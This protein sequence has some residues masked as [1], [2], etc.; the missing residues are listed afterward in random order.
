MAERIFDE[1]TL[2]KLDRLTLIANYK[3]SERTQ[4]GLKWKL[5]SGQPYTPIVG[6]AFI[7]YAPGDTAGY[8][9][10]VPGAKVF[11]DAAWESLDVQ[12]VVQRPEPQG[13]ISSVIDS[14]PPAMKTFSGLG[15]VSRAG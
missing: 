5:A 12:P 13:L 4:L 8:W 14:V 6:R 1:K 7:P 3:W 9:V 11:A 2:R 10:G 15:W